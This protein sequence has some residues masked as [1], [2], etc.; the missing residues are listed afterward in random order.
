MALS[1]CNAS[2]LYSESTSVLSFPI[3][4]FSTSNP[5]VLRIK[6]LWSLILEGNLLKFNQ[7]RCLRILQRIYSIHLSVEEIREKTGRG[8]F[9]K[10]NFYDFEE[11]IEN[12]NDL[13]SHIETFIEYNKN[14]W[15]IRRLLNST[16]INY[17]F[18]N[19][20]AQVKNILEDFSYHYAKYS[21]N[22]NFD[23][24]L[25]AWEEQDQ[26]DLVNDEQNLI[27]KL[28]K[29]WKELIKASKD[30]HGISVQQQKVL[31]IL[32]INRSNIK[33][34]ITGLQRLIFCPDLSRQERIT[35]SFAKITLEIIQ[36]MFRYRIQPFSWAVTSWEIIDI[37][38]DVNTKVD[39]FS[40]N[41]SIFDQY[42]VAFFREHNAVTIRNFKKSAL[43]ID[44]I[45]NLIIWSN[46]QHKN[47]LPLLGANVVIPQPYI[48]N[49]FLSN[50]NMIG[51][52]NEYPHKA[53]N[54]LNE[55]SDAMIYLHTN[56]LVHGDLKGFNVL[57]D[58]EGSVK[59]TNFGF[60][61]I[62]YIRSTLN[63]S[64]TTY[65]WSAPELV[66]DALPTPQSDVYA[67]GILSYEAFFEG[68]TYEKSYIDY[69][70]SH[71]PQNI[72]N[73]PK[74]MWELMQ[75]CWQT[76]PNLRP[77]FDKIKNTVVHLLSEVSSNK[78]RDSVEVSNIE[79][80][81][82]L[83]VS[84][85]QAIT[86]TSYSGTLDN[87]DNVF[88]KNY[89]WI[90]LQQRKTRNNTNAYKPK[91]AKELQRLQKV[92]H[93]N[94]LPLKDYRI[95]DGYFSTVSSFVPSG[96]LINYI[97]KNEIDLVQRVNFIKDM[98]WSS[99]FT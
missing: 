57:I 87:G 11:I 75:E 73:A 45:N 71:M 69:L 30:S 34:V 97:N 82:E 66:G 54:I 38:T 59:I 76:D 56:N 58:Q 64:P 43:K 16:Y 42:K 89:P 95:H 3:S 63:F 85:I 22:R 39:E 86:T 12:L 32:E 33:E 19:W 50:G 62:P 88:I 99:L 24:V 35:Y 83:N 90:C 40:D 14:Q 27:E 28:E 91:V 21:P 94:I 44:F 79:E 48:V 92:D 4:E 84:N 78:S 60:Y 65:P 6:K 51:Y 68:E 80:Q 55:V 29:T 20:K 77:S 81:E 37:Q 17:Q 67:F 26:T 98:H 47:I 41:C 36:K 46:M 18:D 8:L 49:P 74:E 2:T 61:C 7:Q 5:L 25:A 70:L 53:L 9:Q 31:N 1:S 10:E 23:N 96:N 13:L 93:P 15:I 72:S 52:L